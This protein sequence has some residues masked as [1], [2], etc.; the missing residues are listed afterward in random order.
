MVIYDAK[1][2][3]KDEYED[4]NPDATSSTLD[5][6]TFLYE[7]LKGPDSFVPYLPIDFLAEII[8]TRADKQPVPKS[9]KLMDV[10]F[11]GFAKNGR[12]DGQRYLKE[13]NKIF[14]FMASNPNPEQIKAYL[15]FD[16]TKPL[17]LSAIGYVPDFMKVTLLDL[18]L[19]ISDHEPVYQAALKILVTS[20][21]FSQNLFELIDTKF[22][23]LTSGVNE[24]VGDDVIVF[25]PLCKALFKRFPRTEIVGLDYLLTRNH[26][27]P[28]SLQELQEMNPNYELLVHKF[29]RTIT[30]TLTELDII[31]Q[32]NEAGLLD[33]IEHYASHDNVKTIL[34]GKTIHRYYLL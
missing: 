33:G 31:A 32:M 8:R 21:A 23:L 7:Q 25:P 34:S 1:F 30:M 15:K 3:M 17:I 22:P 9:L 5:L 4:Q 20:N 13:I 2:K 12:Y 18:I 24:L 19:P 10:Y 29:L 11:L 16:P 26:A 14:D 6:I 28:F 27:N